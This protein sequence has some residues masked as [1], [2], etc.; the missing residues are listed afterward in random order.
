[1]TP[2][3]PLTIRPSHGTP[4]VKR[5]VRLSVD[6]GVLMATDPHGVTRRFDLSEGNGPYH[7]AHGL[8]GGK[9]MYALVDGTG[10]SMLLV[11]SGPFKSADTE[12]LLKATG[13]DLIMVAENPPTAVDA[14]TIVTPQYL[15]WGM[16]AYYPGLAAWG[17]SYVTGFTWL[18][19]V[20]TI[21]SV[22]ILAVCI[23]LNRAST[24]SKEEVIQ[25]GR[26]VMPEADEAKAIADSWLAAHEAE[27]TTSADGSDGPGPVR[28]SDAP[29]ESTHGD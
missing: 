15:K 25:E 1:M 11:D 26:E 21:P 28:K 3:R 14:L 4:A 12:S 13:L 6:N 20:I 24:G 5:N 27:L 9:S 8:W 29:P 10:H 17:L 22:I 7:I 2:E 23:V 18:I 19:W 16:R